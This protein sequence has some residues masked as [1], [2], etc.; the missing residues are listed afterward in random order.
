MLADWC[1]FVALGASLVG[2]AAEAS[3]TPAQI[4]AAVKQLGDEDF[5]TRER[6]TELLIKAGEAAKAAAESAAKSNDPEVA[7]RAKIIL[8]RLASGIGPHTSPALVALIEEFSN[9]DRNRRTSLIHRL[10]QPDEFRVIWDLIAKEADASQKTTLESVFRSKVASLVSEHYRG[11]RPD[12]SE[13]LLRAT[14]ADPRTEASLLT[15]QLVTGRLPAR[16]DE[17]TKEL[18]A[19][20]SQGGWRRLALLH[21][22]AGDLAK[23]RETAG[24]VEAKELSLWLAAEAADWP[25]ALAINRSLYEG[26]EPSIEQLAFTLLLGYYARDEESLAATKDELAKRVAARPEDSWPAAEALLSA[27]QLDDGIKLL[28]T[29]VPAAAFYLHW[30]RTHYDRAFALAGVQEG[31]NINKAWY[32]ALPD[33][34]VVS[35]SLSIKRP[36]YA[37]DIAGCLQYVGRREDARKVRDLLADALQAEPPTSPSWAALVSTDLRL[38]LRDLAVEDAARGLALPASRP[39]PRPGD[40]VLMNSVIFTELYGQKLIALWYPLWPHVL[41]G[42]GHDSLAALKRI[43][44]LCHGPAAARLS[45]AERRERLLELATMPCGPDGYR[46]GDLLRAVGWIAAR[47]GEEDLAYRLRRQSISLQGS[48]NDAYV[49]QVL[50]GETFRDEDWPGV[51]QHFRRFEQAG[52]SSPIYQDQLALALDKLGQHDEARKVRDAAVGW[53]IDP[54]TFASQGS[55]LLTYGLKPQAAQRYR[56][57]VRLLPPGEGASINALNSLGNAVYEET[58][59]AATPLWQLNMLGPLRGNTNM[60]LDVYVKNLCVIHRVQA[61]DLIGQGKYQEALAHGH[62]ELDAMPGN[63]A[64]IEQLV[65]L[66]DEKGQQSLA[67][68][69][70]NRSFATYAGY[71]EQFPQTTSHRNVLARMAARAKRKLDEAV[72][73][74]DEAIVID[75]DSAELFATLAEVRLARGERDAASAAAKQGLKLEPGHDGCERMLAKARE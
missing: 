21:R 71:C 11:N 57:A 30:Y 59:A 33:G 54:N 7:L 74:I 34:N 19:K 75:P 51:V 61:R 13:A 55:N 40:S 2:Q 56:I 68:E 5:Q 10:S 18:A 47:L 14:T 46:R 38:G 39:L 16:I 58:P 25:A 73:A 31:A 1:L 52:N 72:K 43:E 9:L 48:R 29:S 12:E 15:L 20:P 27:E 36:F 35:T 65:P 37:N 32:D 53:R 67:D 41:A 60:T 44:A 64:V 3:V 28:E 50:G 4:E 45:P 17:L 22:A 62:Q 49:R 69:L 70:F 66:F 23:A 63:V 24:K 26:K 6:A 8:K 42:S